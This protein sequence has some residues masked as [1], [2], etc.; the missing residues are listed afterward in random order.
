MQA[1]AA[2]KDAA[3]A[4]K[5]GYL[6]AAIDGAMSQASQVIKVHDIVLC[7]FRQ[8]GTCQA[9]GL[10]KLCW[11]SDVFTNL[12]MSSSAYEFYHLQKG[13]MVQLQSRHAA[14]NE[15][16]PRG[17]LTTDTDGLEN[18]QDLARALAASLAGAN[19]QAAASAGMQLDSRIGAC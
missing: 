14:S 9:E 8:S 7:F 1:R 15:Q 4:R 18:D 16:G 3:D 13:T 11:S 19:A 5:Q 2:T 6:K 17:S 12:N 10:R